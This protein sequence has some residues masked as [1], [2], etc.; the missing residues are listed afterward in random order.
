MPEGT[1]LERCL[2]N[3]KN[4][5]FHILKSKFFFREDSVTFIKQNKIH[6]RSPLYLFVTFAQDADHKQKSNLGLRVSNERS[7]PPLSLTNFEN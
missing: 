1:I 4:S 3:R 5:N 2:T 6:E 7:G